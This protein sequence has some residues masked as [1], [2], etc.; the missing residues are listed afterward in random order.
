VGGNLRQRA[1]CGGER[2]VLRHDR[3]DVPPLYLLILNVA[4]LQEK[5]HCCEVSVSAAVCTERWRNC[6]LSVNSAVYLLFNFN[7][8]HYTV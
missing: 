7:S 1:V 3:P 4:V 8:E 2:G 5:Q 6:M